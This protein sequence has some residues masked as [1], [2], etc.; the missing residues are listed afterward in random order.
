MT[1]LMADQSSGAGDRGR[2]SGEPLSK[3]DFELRNL[4]HGRL[5]PD[6]HVTT[7]PIP[8]A[9]DVTTVERPGPL[10]FC[11]RQY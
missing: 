2:G 3:L 8:V 6:N 9:S 1:P 11:P 10:S 7:Q 5:H 4:V